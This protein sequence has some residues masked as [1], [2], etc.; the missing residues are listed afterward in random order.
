VVIDSNGKEIQRNALMVVLANATKY[1]TGA[2]I[3][4]TGD[5]YDGLF[6]VVVVKQ[7]AIAEFLRMLFKVKRF[8][9]KNVEVFHTRHVRIQTKHKVHFQ[10]DGEYLGKITQLEASIEAARL[11]FLLPKEAE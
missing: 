4:P 1:G 2:V 9:Q 11:T 8:N 3:N 10:V 5:L 6:E 7:L